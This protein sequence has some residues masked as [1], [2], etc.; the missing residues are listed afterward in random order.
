MLINYRLLAGTCDDS[1][2]QLGN[3]YPEYQANTP[4]LIPDFGQNAHSGGRL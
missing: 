1:L 3:F 2:A 4:A